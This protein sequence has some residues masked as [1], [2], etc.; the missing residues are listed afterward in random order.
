M[1]FGANILH[2]GVLVLLRSLRNAVNVEVLIAG[3]SLI[4]NKVE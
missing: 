1:S 4:G 3:Q 2:L